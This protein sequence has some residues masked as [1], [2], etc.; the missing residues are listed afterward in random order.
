MS[1]GS[2]EK[3]NKQFEGRGERLLSEILEEERTGRFSFYMPT[4]DK[5]DTATLVDRIEGSL[6]S[7]MEVARSPYIV[8]KNEYARVRAEQAGSLTPQGIRMTVKDTKA[9][10]EKDG[11]L[12]PEYVYAKTRE[13]EY[14]TYENRLVRTLIDRTVRFLNLP[15]EYAKDGVKNLYE[16]YFQRA[17]LN[18]LDLM[19]LMDAEL[20]KG[21]D[22]RAF[23]EYKKLFYLRG[24]LSQLR[25]SA[26]YKIMARY[27][28]FTGR[29]EATNLLV[30]NAD[31][32]ACYKLW[33]F[34]DAFNAGL[35]A[36]TQEQQKSVYAAYI[37]LG[38]ASVYVRLGFRIVKEPRIGRID[39]G[40]AP[41]ETVLDDGRFRVT[42]TAEADGL[43][44]LVQCAKIRAQQQ[45][46]IGLH[47]NIAEEYPAEKDFTV[48]LHRTDYSDRMACVVP[49]N[50]QSFKDLESIV[51]CTVLTLEAK[52][53]IYGRL[54]LVCGSNALNDKDYYYQ[55]ED[56]GAAYCFLDE[57][58]VWLNRFHVRDGNA[59]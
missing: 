48:S 39:E 19:K 59:G 23:T 12:R 38:M 52:K 32:N 22:P 20:F 36:L 14:N 31:Y 3:F 57:D 5:L 29:P 11:K 2:L 54:C 8:L 55:C 17:A 34:L 56:C 6:G 26:F 21:S 13:D 7:L 40:F 58:T 44:V 46:T 10:K 45:T 37:L 51:R 43:R 25:G 50:R 28:A 42:L 1:A 16:A 4:S 15:I 30:H 49:G 41:G 24:K 35:S 47:T 33:Q 53:E 9:W 27:P 18:K